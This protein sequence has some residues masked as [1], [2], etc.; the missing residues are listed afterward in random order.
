MALSG[1]THGRWSDVYYARQNNYLNLSD[2][3]IATDHTTTWAD[4]FVDCIKLCR[5]HQGLTLEPDFT[6]SL[7]E[8][9]RRNCK[10]LRFTKG[11]LNEEPSEFGNCYFYFDFDLLLY[12]FSMDWSD[13]IG[14]KLRG[15]YVGIVCEHIAWRGRIVFSVSDWRFEDN[16]PNFLL[17]FLLELSQIN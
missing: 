14:K 2:Y 8:H 15:N 1:F 9:Y 3:G 17:Y 16:F 5:D 4:N 12:T 7:F 10:V 13:N 6:G 11:Q